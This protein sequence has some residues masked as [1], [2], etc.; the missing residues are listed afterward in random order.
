MIR[1][2]RSLYGTS[3]PGAGAVHHIKTGKDQN[4]H[5][6]SG[7]LAKTDIRSARLMSTGRSSACGVALRRVLIPNLP[8]GKQFCGYNWGM[9]GATGLDREHS[10]EAMWHAYCASN[11]A[12]QYR[13]EID[14]GVVHALLNACY[15]DAAS[16]SRSECALDGAQT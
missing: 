4:E 1:L 3:M 2:Q 14:T 15:C 8:Q 6:F 11:F 13:V 16:K 5:V 10:L 7:L 12:R 9:N